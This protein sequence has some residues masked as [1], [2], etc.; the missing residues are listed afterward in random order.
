MTAPYRTPAVGER[1]AGRYELGAHIDSGGM[2]EVWEATDHTL[3]RRV[4]V[5]ILHAHLARDEA[6][7]R[8]F[9]R[10][11]VNAARLQ[12][13][14]IVSIYDAL[15]YD[16]LEAIVME[17]IE[18]RTLRA[19][20]DD[21]GKL[22][23][24]DVVDMGRQIA[25]ALAV[26]HRAGVIHRD[27]KPSNIMLCEDR[28]V[29]VTDFGIAK[30]GEDTDLTRTGT[31]LGTAKYLSP[32]Q[33]LGNEVDDR[34]DLYGLGVVVFEALTG[35]PPFDEGNDYAT[36][37]ARL[38]DDAPRLS[39][40][41]PDLPRTLDRLI[42]E[43]LAE[44]PA[45][46]PDSAEEL[47]TRLAGIDIDREELAPGTPPDRTTIDLRPGSDQT[48]EH[49]LEPIGATR[50]TLSTGDGSGELV[51]QTGGARSPRLS[52]ATMIVLALT[53]SAVVIAAALLSRLGDPD[54]EVAGDETELTDGDSVSLTPVEEY[55]P[56]VMAIGQAVDPL[57]DDTENDDLAG[58][59]IDGDGD[60]AW[61]TETYRN[62]G[63]SGVKPG[64]GYLVT[65]EDPSV[66]T[67][68]GIESPTIGWTAEIYVGDQPGQATAGWEHGPF[69]VSLSD[70]GGEVELDSVTG[71]YVLL[72]ITFE[73]QSE[74]D[75]PD[76]EEPENRFELAEIVIG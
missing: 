8:R 75:D 57:G 7:V 17:R 44:D 13:P 19:V 46:R 72:W 21:H 5:K 65:L 43:L 27:I 69:P 38:L 30:A 61:R 49:R 31:L 26:A 53:A 60:T 40:Y 58:L 56:P 4:A 39:Q 70:S 2:A 11:A 66:I 6:F 18:G 1:V 35:R 33:V 23:A 9:R 41:R 32:E 10:E 16:G 34:S 28:R 48:D 51:E 62:P 71:R 64:V 74:A 54:P 22:P 47:A 25:E 67:R 12:H 37:Q 15:S 24:R 3:G 76:Q 42:A 20:L 36:A 14:A 45:D 73:G 63:F 59:A 50:S 29:R 55:G 68:V 52:A